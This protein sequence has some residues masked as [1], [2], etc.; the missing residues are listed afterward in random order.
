MALQSLKS[1]IPFPSWPTGCNTLPSNGTQLLDAA[2][3]KASTIFIAS[4]AKAIRTIHIRTGTITTG[5]TVDVRVETVDSAANGDPTGTLWTTNSNGALVIASTDDNVWKSV[6]LT[7]DTATLAIGDVFALVVVNGSVPGV[8]NINTYADMVASIPYGDQFTAAWAKTGTCPII[9]PQ[10]SDGSF[11]PLFGFSDCGGFTTTTFNSSSATN[12]RGN[13][14]QV[15]FPTRTKGCWAWVDG[16]G[17]F[18][19]KLYDPDGTTVLATTATANTFQRGAT[20]A[21]PYFL[22]FTGGAVTLTENTNYRLVVIPSTT[23]NLSTFEFDV[24]LAA[25]LDMFPGGQNCHASVYTSGAWVETTTK[26]GYLGVILDQF[27]D[28]VGGGLTAKAVVIQ[29]SGSQ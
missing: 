9:V 14:F 1:G 21:A 27:S 6:T 11:E 16:D 2:G 18:T 19:V 17:D 4:V 5:D 22:P 24:P 29:A 20:T 28:G 26:R 13:I 23:T 12:R 7:A 8:I 10:Y 25:M 3:E 15:P